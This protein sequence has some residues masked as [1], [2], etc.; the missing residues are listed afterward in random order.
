MY[1]FFFSFKITFH[2]LSNGLY[3]LQISKTINFLK[4]IAYLS[5]ESK[6]PFYVQLSRPSRDEKYFCR[7][8]F[9]AENGE[10]DLTILPP[11]SSAPF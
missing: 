8:H 5:N 1:I 7:C 2:M 10:Q 3:I 9:A 11:L 4:S 6:P